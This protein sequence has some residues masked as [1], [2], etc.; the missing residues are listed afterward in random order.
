VRLQARQA[1]A[2]SCRP[3]G[4]A[5][6][7]RASRPGDIAPRKP[8]D[9]RIEDAVGER[10]EAKRLETRL[11]VLRNDAAAAGQGVEIFEDDR[12]IVDP[13]AVVKL[14][15]RDLAERILLAQRIGVLG[16]GRLDAILPSRPSTLTAI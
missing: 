9:R 11:R 6:S 3:A 4:Q 13:A 2:R 1:R 15:D 14:H 5:T 12:Q 10:L 16:G 7:A 8:E